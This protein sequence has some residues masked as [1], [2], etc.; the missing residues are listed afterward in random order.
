MPRPKATHTP[1]TPICQAR[2]RFFS[3]SA[4]HGGR[5]GVSEEVHEAH[6]RGDERGGDAH[7][8]EFCLA[9]LA[10]EG[11]VGEHKDGFGD[12]R[13]EGGYGEDE[14]APVQRRLGGV[15][16]G[17][18][19]GARGGIRGGARYRRGILR[20]RA[21]CSATGFSNRVLLCAHP[22]RLLPA[23]AAGAC[24]RGGVHSARCALGASAA[25]FV[26]GT[27]FLLGG[28]A[29]AS[30]AFSDRR[31]GKVGGARAREVFVAGDGDGCAY[32]FDE[33]FFNFED[34][35]PAGVA[36]AHHV[37]FF[38][39]LGGFGGGVVDAHVAAFAFVGGEG[40]GFKDA[41]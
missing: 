40:A 8:G 20:G 23:A 21:G 26:E 15:R 7:A 39:F 32:P 38:E 12:E 33:E 1:S 41:H 2:R 14:D 24:A 6:D 9:E 4:R 34:A 10:D 16:S 30:F 5:D 28:A 17:V 25:Q 19:T 3:P 36:H 18:G 11:G 35:F 31:H 27:A 37:S 13:A 22:S 29:A